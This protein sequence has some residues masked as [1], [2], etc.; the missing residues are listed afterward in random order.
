M[1]EYL[2]LAKWDQA[3]GFLAAGSPPM[4]VRLMALNALFL[5]LYGIRKAAGAQPMS[6][7]VTLFVQLAVLA[8]NLLVLFQ[9]EVETLFRGFTGRF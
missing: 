3:F 8:V 5:G 9:A 1:L 6:P 7:G 2:Y 4:Y